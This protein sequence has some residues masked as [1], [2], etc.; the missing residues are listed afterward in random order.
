MNCI[1]SFVEIYRIDHDEMTS[2]RNNH[3]QLAKGFVITFFSTL[4]I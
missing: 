1:V 2:E 3:P 4:E